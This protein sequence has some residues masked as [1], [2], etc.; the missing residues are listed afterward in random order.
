MNKEE[1]RTILRPALK[2]LGPLITLFADSMKGN[3][4][5]KDEEL[6]EDKRE[7]D[8]AIEAECWE[9]KDGR[10]EQPRSIRHN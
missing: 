6:I 4:K 9:V 8:A 3:E 5:P 7:K 2:A 1:A 10:N